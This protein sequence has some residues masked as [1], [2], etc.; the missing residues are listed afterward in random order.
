[1]V[2]GPAAAGAEILGTAS[3][4]EGAPA[5]ILSSS[6]SRLKLLAPPYV[7]LAPPTPRGP[8]AE[9][10]TAPAETFMDAIVLLRL[11]GRLMG[12]VGVGGREGEPVWGK[13][14]E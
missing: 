3:A 6:T 14:E 7:F 2:E 9:A 11:R 12:L 5:K 4:P 1:M 8:R 10:S 13:E